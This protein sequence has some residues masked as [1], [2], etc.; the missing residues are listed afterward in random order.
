MRLAILWLIAAPTLFA[1]GGPAPLTLPNSIG[2]L[3]NSGNGQPPS[4]PGNDMIVRYA[5]RR[6]AAIAALKAGNEAATTSRGPERPLGLFLLA[7]RR[8]PSFAAALYDVGIMCARQEKWDDALNFYKEAAKLDKTPELGTLIQAEIARAQLVGSLDRRTRE[9]YSKFVELAARSANPVGTLDEAQKMQKNDATR[10]ELQAIVGSLQAKLGRYDESAKALDAAVKLAPAERRRALGSAADLAR[11]EAT[12]EE[13]L[14]AANENWDK[15][16]YSAAA[17]AYANAWETS[18]ARDKVGMQAATAFLMEDQIPLAVQTLAKLRDTGGP[19]LSA[20]ATL[21]LKELGTVSEEAKQMA[22]HSPGG[23]P[24][25]STAD[26]GERVQTL[27]GDLTSAEMRLASKENP[28]LVRDD[29]PFVTVADEELTS[30]KIDLL[31][32]SRQSVFQMY[33]KAVPSDP[34]PQSSPADLTAPPPPADGL[35][36]VSAPDAPPVAAPAHP[37]KLETRPTAPPEPNPA[38]SLYEGAPRINF[39]AGDRL[40]LSLTI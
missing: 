6:E 15:Q 32:Q 34:A 35:P 22:Q 23:L 10:W 39:I 21:M 4:S 26:V 9:F 30:D 8:D 18:P 25:E 37:Q 20:K 7:A 28:G 27:L 16:E 2:R 12:F 33:R 19:D 17:Q 14:R 24:P 3:N 29:T 1:Q 40:R 11:L 5:N 13:Q 36:P 38:A 31:L